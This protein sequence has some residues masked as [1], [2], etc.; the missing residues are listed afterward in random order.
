MEHFKTKPLAP[1]KLHD[2]ITQCHEKSH[3]VGSAFQKKQVLHALKEQL[4]HFSFTMQK[5]KI[6]QVNALTNKNRLLKNS[7]MA[8]CK[9]K[10][11]N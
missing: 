1:L 11:N 7:N 10:I 4:E 3:K 5:Y 2:F 8:A 9:L 6:P